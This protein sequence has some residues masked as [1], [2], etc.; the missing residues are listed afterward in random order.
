MNPY[1]SFL[2][3]QDPIQV[4]ST[5]A[6]QLA[7]ISQTLGPARI[8]QSP[9]PG[10]WSPREIIIHLAD[11][12]LAFAF[13]YRQ[14]LGEANHVIQPFDQDAWAKSYSAYDA[15]Q[16]LETFTVLRNWNLALIRTLTPEQLSKA[17]SHPERG[18]MDLRT[19]V[20]TA[21]GH[22]INHLQQLERVANKPAA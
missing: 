1:A 8:N 17:V 18:K 9:A 4:L 10:K 13:R 19:I 6:S 12:E 2:G 16:A 15:N 11:C 7:A 14:T 3:N 21:A 22:D 20:E 5:T